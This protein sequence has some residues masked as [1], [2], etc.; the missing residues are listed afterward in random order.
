MTATSVMTMNWT[1]LFQNKLLS[2]IFLPFNQKR[3]DVATSKLISSKQFSSVKILTCKSS[4]FKITTFSVAKLTSLIRKLKCAICQQRKK[5]Q[6]KQP[7]SPLYSTQFSTFL[8]CLYSRPLT[9]DTYLNTKLLP[10]QKYHILTAAL[11]EQNIKNSHIARL[12]C[13]QY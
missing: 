6:R 4:C 5:K 11:S 3:P 1:I 13:K 7:Y 2:Y 9:H 12:P 10:L 8:Q